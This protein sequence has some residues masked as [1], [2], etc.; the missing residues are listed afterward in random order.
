[1]RFPEYSDLP[2]GT[3]AVIMS[4]YYY[5]VVSKRLE[6]LEID[7]YYSVLYFLSLHDGCSQQQICNSL[8]TDKTA[9]VKIM[10]YLLDVGYIQRKTNPDDRR[11]QFVSL[12][13]KGKERAKKVVKVF[14]DLDKQMLADISKREK[15]SFIKTMAKLTDKL[16]SMPG[17]E[18]F[19]LMNKTEKLKK[20]A[21]KKK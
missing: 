5:G 9:M 12:T 7:R 11:E 17:T 10:N 18:V 21:F 14:E 15:E 16:Q 8:A 6:G 13:R 3:T 4:K 2:I 1:M 20:K 19:F